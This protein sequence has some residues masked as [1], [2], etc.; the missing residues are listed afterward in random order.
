MMLSPELLP[1]RLTEALPPLLQDAG[2]GESWRAV[3]LT[4]DASNRMYF[5]IHTTETTYIALLPIVIS[6]RVTPRR[7]H[8]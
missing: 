2:A 5:R 4:G 3:K 8:A 7:S 1:T 6:A